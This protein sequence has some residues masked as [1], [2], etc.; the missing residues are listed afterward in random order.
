[1]PGSFETP[2]NHMQRLHPAFSVSLLK[3]ALLPG[4]LLCLL[5]SFVPLPAADSAEKVL[6]AQRLSMLKH[7]TGILI[8][9]I[10]NS[11]DSP[12]RGE[13]IRQLHEA[14]MVLKSADFWLRYLCPQE[15]RSL[16]GP[17][18]TEWETEVFE[19]YERPYRRI[20]SGL[21]LLELQL[22][23]DSW[24]AD[25][26]LAL[27]L[28]CQ[29]TLQFLASDSIA[30]LLSQYHHGFLCN[31]LFLLNLAT[32]YTTGFECPDPERMAPELSQMLRDTRDIYTA[33]NSDFP[34]TPF[35]Q[36]YLQHYD[37][38]IAF[39]DSQ[40]LHPDSFS[41]FQL[42]RDHVNPL[43]AINQQLIRKYA[44]RSHSY[45]D[46]SINNLCDRIFDKS[47]YR[48][49]YEKGVFGRISSE[50]DLNLLRELG[51][52]LFYDPILSGNLNR[53]CAS[54][55]IPEQAFT[56]TTVSTSLAADG[57][58]R[59]RRNTPTLLN[60]QYNHLAMLDGLHTTL[61]QQAAAVIQNPEEM[62]GQETRIIKYVNSCSTYKKGFAALQK[63]TPLKPKLQL[64][65][66][67]SAIIWYYSSFSSASAPFDHMING[68]TNAD[69]MV[70]AGF[71]LFMGKAQCATCHFLP[72]FNGVK[73]PYIGSEFEVI[74]VPADTAF[75]ALSPDSGRYL[76]NPAT[77]TLH[78]FRTGSLRNIARTKPYMHNGV[79]A[80]LQQVIEFYN[81]GGG[82]GRGLRVPN[83]TLSAEPLH[84]TAAEI[85]QLTLFLQSLSEQYLPPTVPATLPVSSIKKANQRQVRGAF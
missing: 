42:I 22:G 5:L 11:G 45:M 59:L 23:E 78:A 77:E 67:S 52:Q 53:S 36:E 17:L 37:Q 49:Q 31:R 51:R 69:P 46:Y 55:H 1:M 60:A 79:F 74:G 66:I 73:P 9:Q 30:G 34:Q 58:T 10:R 32:I 84:L 3:T 41:H 19:K 21:T 16:N 44:V 20:G 71:N 47:L 6:F 29:S 15:Y 35:S 56:D 72:Q 75:K 14:R 48:G 18:R 57:R 8:Q 26:A 70:V 65:H 62:Q 40:A 33:F 50:A 54:C 43:F 83:Q 12:D 82:A 61:L 38:L 39:A 7:K 2:L 85:Q 76:V 27:M 24:N 25:S 28:P 64:E 63:Y 13:F 81:N 68:D 80:S 4:F